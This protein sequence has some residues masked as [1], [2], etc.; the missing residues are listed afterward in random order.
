MY[1]VIINGQNIEVST[2][3]IK[4]SL[5]ASSGVATLQSDISREVIS[6]FDPVSI[7]LQGEEVFNGFVSGVQRTSFP[8][9]IDIICHTNLDKAQRCFTIEEYQSAGETTSH[10]E[11][12]FFS[13]AQ[14][15]NYVIQHENFPVYEGYSWG[16]QKIHDHLLNLIQITDSRLYTDR[17]GQAHISPLSVSNSVFNVDHYVHVE[18]TLSDTSIRNKVVVF[19]ALDYQGTPIKAILTADNPYLVDGE[20]RVMSVSSSLIETQK[21]ALRLA[22]K[23]LKTFSAP[24]DIRTYIIEG[25]PTLSLNDFIT[26]PLGEGA[27]TSLEHSYTQESFTTTITIGEICPAFFGMDLSSNLLFAS[28]V[29]HGVWRTPRTEA[30]W[31]QIDPTHLTA[32]V[33]AI[34]VDETF[35]WAITDNRVLKSL[36]QETMVWEE[37]TFPSILEITMN[38]ED[39]R[40]NE[41]PVYTINTTN[42]IF[43]DIITD[44]TLNTV[45]IVTHCPV[46]NIGVMLVSTDKLNFNRYYRI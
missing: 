10:W 29:D 12:F 30:A 38:S 37:C 17:H 21:G 32:T 45:Y 14:I 16:R 6:T 41:I 3:D 46:Y 26:T 13:L 34:H 40:Y 43:K 44:Y 20:V 18:Q 7:T 42:L 5:C 25:T 28:T 8:S 35:L 19:G 2:I 27:I 9:T 4:Y 15:D 24:L 22:R 11:Q 1:T 31:T 36:I 23:M 39:M 33:N